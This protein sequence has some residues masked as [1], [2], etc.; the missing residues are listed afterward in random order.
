MVLGWSFMISGW[1]YF[2]LG[3]LSC[4]FYGSRLVFHDFGWVF[5]IA[6]SS[7]SVVYD[8]RWV[9]MVVHCPRS[10]IMILGWFLGWYMVQC[11][12]FMILGWF[13]VIHGSMCVFS[14]FLILFYGFS[15]FQV[16]LHPSWA[17]EARSETLRTPQKVPA[18]S[19]RPK[20]DFGFVMMMTETRG[21]HAVVFH[22][23]ICGCGLC[24]LIRAYL[25]ETA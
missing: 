10:G 1:F 24:R 25:H 21:G 4:F 18:W 22:M 19:C 3:G 12:F 14:W 11:L 20:A 13:W 8:S 15:W 5:M 16:G 6:Y 17:A 7:R 2:V 9:S 23:R